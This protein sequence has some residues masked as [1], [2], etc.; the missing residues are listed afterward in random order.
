MQKTEDIHL[1]SVFVVVICKIN[2]FFS[3]MSTA[4]AKGGGF[5]H[6]SQPYEEDRP[7]ALLGLFFYSALMFTLP[8]VSFFAKRFEPLLGRQL[9]TKGGVVDRV[10]AEHAVQRAHDH[11]VVRVQGI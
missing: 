11:Y 6:I 8:L 9:R 1:I 2:F 7:S 10:V 5:F 4:E 3:D